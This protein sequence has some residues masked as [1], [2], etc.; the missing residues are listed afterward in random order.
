[1]KRLLSL[2]L[3]ACLLFGTL[4]ATALSGTLGL[5]ENSS[6]VSAAQPAESAPPPAPEVPA[7]NAPPE[8]IAQP[9]ASASTA[10]PENTD[11]P[12]LVVPD[13]N[14]ATPPVAPS[15]Q[16]SPDTFTAPATPITATLRVELYDS[17]WQ[18]PLEVTMPAEYRPLSF[19]GLNVKQDPGY[20]TPLHLLAEYCLSQKLSPA[21]QIEV[22]PTGFVTNFMSL[23]GSNHIS[24]S[25][26]SLLTDTSFMFAVNDQYPTRENG[27]G[28]TLSDYPLAAGDTV[29]LY[30]MWF[31]SATIGGHYA[32]FTQKAIS[33]YTG[34]PIP[35][36]MLGFFGMTGANASMKDAELLFYDAALTELTDAEA[37]AEKVQSDGTTTAVFHK[38]GTYIVSAKRTSGYYHNTPFVPAQDISRPYALVKITD[39]P[40]MT[41]A[42]AVV[43]DKSI[44]ELG[45]LSAVTANLTLPTAGRRGTTIVWETDHAAITTTGT[46]TRPAY[47]AA[48]QK[49]RLTATIR[50]GAESATKEF[51]ALVKAITKE[52]AEKDLAAAVGSV[53]VS[54]SPSVAENAN[55]LTMWRDKLSAAGHTDI[56]VSVLSS[57][58]PNIAPDG[59]ITFNQYYYKAAVTLRF[60]RFDLVYDKK[61]VYTI[62]TKSLTPQERV[63]TVA[64]LLSFEDIKST[65]TDA[66]FVTKSLNN[67]TKMTGYSSVKI[68]WKSNSPAVV[69][70]SYSHSVK[71]PALGQAD[72]PVVL[73]ATITASGATA[74][75]KDISFTVAA[76]TTALEK[77]NLSIGAI[78]FSP[79]VKS[80]AVH[81]PQ[82]TETL[83]ITAQPKDNA[84][85]K[86]TIGGSTFSSNGNKEK[87]ATISLA[88]LVTEVPVSVT[89]SDQTETTTLTLV[90]D[91]PENASLPA[92]W[93]SFRKDGTANAV[94]EDKNAALAQETASLLW[95]SRATSSGELTSYPGSPLSVGGKLYLARDNKLLML[96]PK[97]GQTEKEVALSGSTGYAAMV[98]YAEGQIF[99]PLTGGIVECIDAS[100]MRSLWR[101]TALGGSTLQALAPVSY[102]HGKVFCGFYDYTSQSG[103][104][105]M[106]DPATAPNEKGEK[107]WT[108][109]YG[110][111]GCYGSGATKAENHVVLADESGVLT[112]LN[113]AGNPLDTATLDGAVRCLPVFAQNAVYV[114][115]A[116]GSLYRFEIS[117]DKLHQTAKVK[118]PASSVCSP[119]IADGLVFTVGGAF[120]ENGF[121]AVYDATTLA[122]Y[123]EIRTAGAIQSSPL[124][125]RTKEGVALYAVQNTADGS[126]LRFSYQPQQKNL[127]VQ[128]LYTPAVQNYA[129]FSP[130]LTEDGALLYGNDSGVLLALALQPAPVVPPVVP[131][132]P[133][134]PDI[135]TPAP[136]QGGHA[137]SSPS[138]PAKKKKGVPSF[139]KPEATPAPSTETFTKQLA[140]LKESLDSGAAYCRIPLSP[141][142]LVARELIVQW[143]A[144]KEGTLVLDYGS[145]T[146]SFG[147][148]TLAVPAEDFRILLEATSLSSEQ[149]E[150]FG[151]DAAGFRV[152]A[153][154]LTFS[155][156]FT[157][158]LP[159]TGTATHCYPIKEDGSLGAPVALTLQDG[160]AMCNL[161]NAGNYLL[162]NL[163]EVPVPA[164]ATP[165]ASP[166]PAL[167][168]FAGVASVLLAAFVILKKKSR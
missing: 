85:S 83:V 64:E 9:D 24:D 146:V 74:K 21:E 139:I 112:L 3:A 45:D 151:A 65:N 153:E 26:G 17:T 129:T 62:N 8:S 37:T 167:A 128:T 158:V 72:V 157:L 115:T 84:T 107:G 15:A 55:L 47:P 123:A 92:F 145:Y 149:K 27:I 78:D 12:S 67:V 25:H 2:L 4:P 44:L 142:T 154:G 68:S 73:T 136:G 152:T 90:R 156:S 99:V 58:N 50:R 140:A 81:L 77:L 164:G 150:Q 63:D 100:T 130:V 52:E 38:P 10:V 1:M 35:F 94:V 122:S 48:D 91:L 7:T 33:G 105:A 120:G 141:E 161:Q 31:S 144:A 132:T 46:I 76:F 97:T 6:A 108:T 111:S 98:A 126:L 82:N 125:M 86:L 134:V 11:V 19:Y 96:N 39:P 131:E 32:Y 102:L 116:K 87:S 16:E 138:A 137:A 143:N 121:C 20:F 60:K 22:T 18:L 103:T 106:L 41:D 14:T 80:Y 59:S 124:A 117:S 110:T 147:P 119:V 5:P 88:G 133:S 49:V 75:T 89:C 160:Y 79:S 13:S 148:D 61:I 51:N 163:P 114:T 168:A 155:G 29:V 23:K 36:Q 159:Y 109:T 40:P 30:D 34:D 95:E 66:S 104:I 118:L 93:G 71:R 54:S 53:Y 42:E 127:Q 166:I 70:G 69:I 113:A 28:Y 57:E 43:Y 56:E 135:I 165:S 101:T 162:A